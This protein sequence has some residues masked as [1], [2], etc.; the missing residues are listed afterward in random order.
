MINS[1]ETDYA[2]RI[3]RSLAGGQR[4]KVSDVCTEM[5]IPRSFAYKIIQ[6]LQEADLV[7]CTR[8]VSGGIE[9]TERLHEASMLDVFEVF[10]DLHGCSACCAADYMCSLQHDRQSCP[11]HRVFARIQQQN[12]ELLQSTRLQD[13]FE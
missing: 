9:G 13:L 3:L 7:L 4:R 1:R 12:R 10:G 5:Q 6:K 8:G 2:L 11:F